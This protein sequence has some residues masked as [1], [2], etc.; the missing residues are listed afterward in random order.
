M[1][2]FIIFKIVLERYNLKSIKYIY[3]WK[4]MILIVQVRVNT[5]LIGGIVDFFIT[6]LKF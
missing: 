4:I 2:W 5:C 1:E 3:T 6:F